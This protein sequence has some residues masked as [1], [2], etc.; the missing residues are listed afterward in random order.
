MKQILFLL[1]V[2]PLFTFG[3]WTQ[4]GSDI[5][6]EAADD[7]SGFSVS[8]SADGLTVAV[9]AFRNDGSGTDAGHVR[10]YK[11]IGGVWTQQG[12]DIDGEFAGDFSGLSVSMS[13]DGLTLAIGAPGNDDSGA[14][15]GHTRV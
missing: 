9:G 13:A 11:L 8:M 7:W 6:G 3:Q 4:R 12:A 14:E 10:V 15:A 2:A 1:L 5:N